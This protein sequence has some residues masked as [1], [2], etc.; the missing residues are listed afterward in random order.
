MLVQMIHITRLYV[1]SSTYLRQRLKSLLNFNFSN[2]EQLRSII[3]IDLQE[4][5]NTLSRSLTLF[6]TNPLYLILYTELFKSVFLY[7]L[8]WVC[9]SVEVL[10]ENNGS[11]RCNKRLA[12]SLATTCM[13]LEFRPFKN[14]PYECVLELRKTQVISSEG[15]K[16][17]NQ[18]WTTLSGKYGMGAY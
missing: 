1:P 11:M 7:G 5:R 9:Y 13:S 18:I 17:S 2:V 15:F 4:E 12:V 3:C 16:C 10:D 8:I 14:M 6:S